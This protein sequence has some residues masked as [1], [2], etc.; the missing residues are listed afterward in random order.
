MHLSAEV[1]YQSTRRA[2]WNQ[3]A[4]TNDLIF[5][6]RKYYHQRLA[7]DYQN[8]I[9]AKHKVLEIGCA[10][11]NL[12]AAIKP[13][14]GV[15]IDI[16]ETMLSCA[17]DKYPHLNFIQANGE[18]IPLDSTFDFII[19]SDLLND[20]WDG[21]ALFEEI[22][23]V[24]NPKTRIVINTY[25]RLWQF[26]LNIAQKL[27]LARPTLLQN[28]FTP[29]DINNLLK[30]TGFE[31]VRHRTDII[32]P[33]NIPL[34][35]P[36][37]NRFLGKLWPF[38][39]LS[40]THIMVAKITTAA[41][42][43]DFSVSVLVPA[44]NEEGNIANIFARVPQMGKHTELIFVEGHSQDNTYETIKSEIKK[45]PKWDAKLFKQPGKGK[46]D[47]V[48]AGFAQAT[49]DI[50]MILDADLTVPP[51]DL[52]RFLA[53][54]AEGKG[55]FINGVRLVYPM[56]KEAMRFLNLLGNKF[57]SLA[58]TW[59]LEQ[60]IRDS[61]C[62]TKVLSKKDYERIAENRSYFGDFDPF[63]D[64]DLLFGAARQNMKIVEVPIRYRER[65]YGDTNIDRWRHGL[66]L[67]RMV[68]LAARR[69]K[70]I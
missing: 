2:H 34:L 11:G 70:F 61:L 56:E 44:R 68:V 39:I 43:D 51:E 20:V 65:T 49:G 54:I 8:I 47:A 27:K 3:I 12:L 24:S 45:H 22:R 37:L 29:E 14:W 60:N 40:L 30:L 36:L 50:L 69:I 23:R 42:P 16:S 38:N 5:Q 57:F 1:N 41:N 7:F 10:T 48:R 13:A 66:L 59:L 4:E 35:T 6:I 64:F 25:S 9:P 28:W 17:K 18:Q 52:P 55:E 58:F 32:F 33:F 19:L 62:G 21:Q 31:L 63:G 46:G 15:G 53:A 67:L 26:P